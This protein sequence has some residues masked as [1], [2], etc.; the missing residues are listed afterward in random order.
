MTEFIFVNIYV[1]FHG[2]NTL[3]PPAGWLAGASGKASKA[4][5]IFISG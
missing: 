4:P 1:M 3:R 2:F 5:P